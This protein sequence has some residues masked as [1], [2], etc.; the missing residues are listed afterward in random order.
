MNTVSAVCFMAAFALTGYVLGCIRTYRI[1]V[2]D[3]FNVCGKLINC[4]EIEE[5]DGEGKA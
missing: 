5:E 4:I 2:R 1:G 3:G